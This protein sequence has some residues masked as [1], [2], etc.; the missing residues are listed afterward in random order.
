MIFDTP[1]T[2]R[3]NQ[4]AAGILQA[5]N[6]MFFA[7]LGQWQSGIS[8]VWDDPNPQGV[9]S[10]LGTQ[11]AAVF[12]RAAQLQA[13]LESQVPGCTAATVAKIRPVT[14]N[15]DGTVTVNP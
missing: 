13:F 15:Q 6:A 2:V 9:I 12:T 14:L 3:V 5:G 4:K 7:M 8:T 1:D 11:A 10:A